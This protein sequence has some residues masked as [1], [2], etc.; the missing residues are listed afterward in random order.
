MQLLAPRTDQQLLS[1]V[2]L[3]EDGDDV[4]NP[5]ACAHSLEARF[6]HRGHLVSPQLAVNSYRRLS[7]ACSITGV[8]TGLSPERH[9]C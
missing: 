5:G 7:N 3:N 9:F 2:A 4:R 1:C 6:A 8:F